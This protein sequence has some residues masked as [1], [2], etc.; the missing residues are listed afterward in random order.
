MNISGKLA[1][2]WRCLTN[3]TATLQ[4]PSH[5]QEKLLAWILLFFILFS[6]ATLLI[7]LIFNPHHDP[8]RNQYALLIG[9]LVVFLIFAYILNCAKYYLASAI[10]LVTSTAIV[11]WASLSFD[12]SILQG[13]IIPLTYVTFS[14]LLSSIF[15]PVHIT[16]T[17]A[18]L[19]FTGVI[20]VLLISPRYDSLNWF[21]FLAFVFVTSIFGLVANSIIQRD[22]KKI[23]NQAHQLALNEALLKEQVIRDDLTGL[24]NRRYLNEMFE[25]EIQR[26]LRKQVP[27]CVVVLDVDDFKQIN[28]TFGHAVGDAVLRELAN[29]LGKKVRQSDIACRYGGDEFVLVLPETSRETTIE[30]VEQLQK[31]IKGINFQTDISI[32]AGIA[33]V[34][35]NGTDG[36]TLLK[37]ADSALYQAKHEGCN[38]VVVAN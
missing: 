12:H 1:L 2:L 37:S 21:S 33:S 15:L 36:E 30:R 32:S 16:F 34:P 26:T 38:R 11:P 5:R 10:L 28:D 23:T 9:S 7:V 20:L 24:F 29:F 35:E 13:D 19:H 6:I 3:P 8:V 18:A 4:Q 25:R 22:M 31:G 14:V 17:L 27:L